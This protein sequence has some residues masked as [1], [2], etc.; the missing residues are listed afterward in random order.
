MNINKLLKDLK[1]YNLH[2][3][4]SNYKNID[5][6][7]VIFNCLLHNRDN[8]KYTINDFINREQLSKIDINAIEK[9]FLI[10]NIKAAQLPILSLYFADKLGNYQRLIKECIIHN[11]SLN[12][13]CINAINNPENIYYLYLI[14]NKFVRYAVVKPERTKEETIKIRKNLRK[15]KLKKIYL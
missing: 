14:T 1:D 6:V 15:E 7:I 2:T 9:T 4:S 5:S 13:F 3:T 12:Q 11:I 8:N 10:P